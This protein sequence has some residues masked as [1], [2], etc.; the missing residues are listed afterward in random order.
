MIKLNTSDR[1]IMNETTGILKIS[2]ILPS[3]NGIYEC[4]ASNSFGTQSY[5]IQLK[6]KCIQYFNI[7]LI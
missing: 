3:D 5:K 7:G 6:V 1:I 4:V 2:N